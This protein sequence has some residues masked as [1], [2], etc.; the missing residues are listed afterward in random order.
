[1]SRN[2]DR[3]PL[4]ARAHARDDC[5]L[6]GITRRRFALPIFLLIAFGVPWTGWI[7][8]ELIKSP[9][10]FEMVVANFWFPAACSL[11]GFI[12]VTIENGLTGLRAFTA[13]VFNLRFP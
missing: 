13:R 7:G 4:L 5:S 11:A 12:A 8:L 9:T 1:M 6:S 2:S 10:Q 3:R